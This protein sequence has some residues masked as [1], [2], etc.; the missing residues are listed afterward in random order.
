[1]AGPDSL[2]LASLRG[3]VGADLTLDHVRAGRPATATVTPAVKR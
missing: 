3:R 2:V 1:V